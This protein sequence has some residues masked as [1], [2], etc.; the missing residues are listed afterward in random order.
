[1]WPS[2]VA[3][4][5][6]QPPSKAQEERLIRR[7]LKGGGRQAQKQAG[8]VSPEASAPGLAWAEVLA[9]FGVGPDSEDELCAW[10]SG[11]RHGSNP[12]LEDDMSE[13]ES[14]YSEADVEQ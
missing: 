3:T 4:R 8:E 11:P 14:W 10:A 2:E 13:A 7:I 9:H 5:A 6:H 12:D 1:M